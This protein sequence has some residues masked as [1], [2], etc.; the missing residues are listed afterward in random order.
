[1]NRVAIVR[2]RVVHDDDY[3]VCL[4]SCCPL[5]TVVVLLQHDRTL[6]AAPHEASSVIARVELMPKF[7]YTKL[8]LRQFLVLHSSMSASDLFF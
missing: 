6:F 5:S 1:M 8:A 2:V 7:C 4:L 3:D